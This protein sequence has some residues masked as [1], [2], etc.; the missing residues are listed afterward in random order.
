MKIS[1]FE[2]YTP[3]SQ[4]DVDKLIETIIAPRSKNSYYDNIVI[5]MIW[6]QDFVDQKLSFVVIEEDYS[7]HKDNYGNY[8]LYSWNLKSENGFVREIGRY[9]SFRITQKD[10]REYKKKYGKPFDNALDNDKAQVEFLKLYS[11]NMMLKRVNK[12][13]AK[14]E[15][16]QQEIDRLNKEIVQSDLLIETVG[17]PEFDGLTREMMTKII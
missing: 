16:L 1:Q 8:T 10:L 5:K 14:A 11:K 15:V 9:S 3:P 7:R 13:R 4:E 12:V 17:N 2:N 6:K